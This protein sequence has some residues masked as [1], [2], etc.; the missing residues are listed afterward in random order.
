MKSKPCR[1]SKQIVCEANWKQ[2]ICCRESTLHVEQFVFNAELQSFNTCA[3][4]Q[5]KISFTLFQ[6]KNYHLL[7][8][9]CV[10]STSTDSYSSAHCTTP[11]STLCE[12]NWDYMAWCYPA[13]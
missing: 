5:L 6:L 10:H 13:L 8:L 2:L 11:H 4:Y 7:E 9:H 3:R 1:I 12:E